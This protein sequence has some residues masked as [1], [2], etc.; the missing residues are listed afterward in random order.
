[1]RLTPR[2]IRLLVIGQLLLDLM[3]IIY[4]WESIMWRSKVTSVL[5]DM[6]KQSL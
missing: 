6:M 4:A 1:M 3:C 5:V 2:A